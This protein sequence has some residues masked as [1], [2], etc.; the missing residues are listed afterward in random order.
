MGINSLSTQAIHFSSKHVKCIVVEDFANGYAS[1]LSEAEGCSRLSAEQGSGSGNQSPQSVGSGA[2]DS[3]TEYLSD[4]TTDH[5]DVTMSLCG[6][7]GHTS[8]INKGVCVS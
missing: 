7:T 1:P 3:G 2:M 4:S 6:H 8:Q 5:M